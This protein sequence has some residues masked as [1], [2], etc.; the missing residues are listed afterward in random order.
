LIIKGG[1]IMMV[2]A[3]C[4]IL[5]WAV[6]LERGLR[7]WRATRGSERLSARVAKLARAGKVADAME[8]AQAEEGCVA[9]VLKAGLAQEGRDRAQ[10]SDSMERRAAEQVMDLESRIGVL[11]TLASVAPYIGLLGTVL[12]IINAFRAL[13]ESKEAGAAVVSAGIA[14]ALVA[15]AAG[16]IVAVPSAIAY[17]AYARKAASLDTRMALASSELVEALADRG[18]ARAKEDKDVEA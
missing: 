5:S 16:L 12:G 15:T 14:E 18:G 10:L 3:V 6:I 17:N 13:A 1:P 4:S 11:G 2:L 7:Y 8:L 9:E